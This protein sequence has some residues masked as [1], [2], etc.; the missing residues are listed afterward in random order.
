MNKILCDVVAPPFLEPG[1]SPAL[2]LEGLLI[3]GGAGII[4]FF[5]RKGKKNS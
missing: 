2:V 4:L 1:V 5:L 3:A